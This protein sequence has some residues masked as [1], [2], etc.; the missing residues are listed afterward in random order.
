MIFNNPEFIKNVKLEFSALRFLTPMLL[1]GLFFWI[2]WDIEEYKR[3]WQSL[4]SIEQIH[5]KSLF[6][7]LCGFG[8]FFTIIWGTYLTSNNMMEEIKVKTWDFV[9]MSSL[10]PFKILTG[11]M[12]GVNC[13]VWLVS[14]LCVLPSI[15]YALRVMI[16]EDGIIR[17]ESITIAVFIS[18]LICWAILSY[19]LVFLSVLSPSSVNGRAGAFGATLAVLIMGTVIGADLLG[20]L[21]NFYEI[22]MVRPYANGIPMALQANMVSLVDGVS[23]MRMPETTTWYSWD[24]YKLDYTLMLLSFAAFWTFVGAWRSLRKSL[25]YFDAPWVWLAFIISTCV[26]LNGFVDYEMQDLVRTSL[27]WPLI[28]TLFLTMLTCVYEASDQLNYKALK[29]KLSQRQYYEAFRT[30]PL[31]ILSFGIFIACVLINFFLYGASD[32]LGVVLLS[33]TI[34]MLRDL[35]AVHIISWKKNIRRPLV[36]IIIYGLIFYGFLPAV[37]QSSGAYYF[38]PQLGISE[39]PDFYW[40]MISVQL[41]VAAVWVSLS[42][43][44]VMREL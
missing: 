40:L 44:R 23:Y 15:I 34:F 21:E 39:V 38:F 41:A 31:W 43:R 36:G 25:Q 20:G 2:G 24:L 16:P 35:M 3:S 5:A 28:V 19:S 22:L 26:F 11:K 7:W 4:Y 17:P 29:Q 14:L 30:T 32:R 12:I 1:L 42:W 18:C 33:L 37:A 10:S 27:V 9:R 13:V 8:F 6:S